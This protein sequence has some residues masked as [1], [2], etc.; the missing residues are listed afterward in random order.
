[1]ASS[2]LK[3]DYDALGD[4]QDQLTSA[5]K[6]IG[7]EFEST[8]TLAATCGDGILGS[9]IS[10]FGTSWNKHRFDIRDKLQWLS[11]SVGMIREQMA[12]ADA[13]LADGLQP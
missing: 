5:L 13:S 7:A 12:E 9:K 6:V 3:V 10:S 11:D 1:M 2:D 8:Q 4:L